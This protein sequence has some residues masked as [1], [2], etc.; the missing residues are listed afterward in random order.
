MISACGLSG[1]VSHL[2]FLGNWQSTPTCLGYLWY[3]GLDMQLYIA[4]P[5]LLHLLHKKPQ[6]AVAV[7]LL[8]VAASAVLRAG[9]CTVYGV[10]NK[11]DVDIPVSSLSYR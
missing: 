10:C 7:S 6:M 5:F 9:Y 8:A 2:T 3:L 1:L 11:S 4:A